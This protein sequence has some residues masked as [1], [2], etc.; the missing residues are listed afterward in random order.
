M[1]R[2]FDGRNQISLESSKPAMFGLCVIR[3]SVLLPFQLLN[4]STKCQ[5]NVVLMEPG[6]TSMKPVHNELPGSPLAQTVSGLSMSVV[7]SQP[8]SDKKLLLN[9]YS[10]GGCVS[11][12]F[13]ARI[14]SDMRDFM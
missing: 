8:R 13:S 12:S 5:R 4:T 11:M 1:R 7:S 6:I 9:L 2:L 14:L 10:W 3:V